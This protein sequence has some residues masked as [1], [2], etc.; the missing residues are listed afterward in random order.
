MSLKRREFLRLSAATTAA[1][2][3]GTFNLFAESQ[4][5]IPYRVLGKTGLKVSLLSLGGHTVGMRHVTEKE[6]IRLPGCLEFNQRLP[7]K[8]K[9]NTTTPQ[10]TKYTDPSGR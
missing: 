2:S 6:S 9:N 1:I 8:Y 4:N 10:Q 5:D 7:D 3:L